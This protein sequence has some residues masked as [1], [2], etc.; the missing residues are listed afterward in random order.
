MLC[1]QYTDH[2]PT[3]PNGPSNTHE[4]AGTNSISP[5]LNS[6]VQLIQNINT[7]NSVHTYTYIHTHTHTHT[8]TNHDKRQSL[9][10][11]S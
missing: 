2:S 6:T 8:H 5:V 9:S 4:L 11:V 10:T 1:V 3:Q 7:V